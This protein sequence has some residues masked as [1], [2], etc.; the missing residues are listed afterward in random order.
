M[1]QKT[2]DRIAV[3][4]LG[5]VGLP[6]AVA[7]A[8]HF[9]V[10]GFDINPTRI[11]ELKEGFDRTG[12]I[13]SET[14]RST[15]LVSTT[16]PKD[17][18]GHTIYI[19]TV[20]TPVTTDNKPDLTPLQKASETVGNVIPRGA[21]VV[22]E[23]TVYPGVTEDFCGPIIEKCSGFQSGIDFFLGYSPE[24]INP[25][26]TVHTVDKITKVIAGQ[27]PEVVAKL[28][29]LYGNINNNN[30]FIAKNIKTAEA[31]KVIENTQ[32]DINIAFINDITMIV[33][34]LGGV[35]IYDV[36]AA[37]NTKWNF[38]PFQPG[39]VGGHCIGVD[40]YY[41]A[42][43]AEKLGH[44]SEIILAGR[45]TNENMA[46]F[47]ASTLSK[48]FSEPKKMLVLGLT[49]KEDIPDLRNTKVIELIRSLRKYGHQVDVHDPCALPEEAERFLGIQLQSQLQDLKEYDCVIGTVPHKGYR[50]FTGDTFQQL[51][52]PNGL[53]ADLK[54][55]WSTIE[56]P[57][58][59]GYW[60]L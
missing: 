44:Q 49:F 5:Y 19:I 37:A 35:S 12:E 24:R 41:L 20:P 6:L 56:L 42:E 7:L 45:R 8:K 47:V 4:G 54:N 27:T 46:D 50:A 22:F 43:C 18:Q 60:R 55:I 30:L 51:L 13:S 36:L 39:L 52:N 1:H 9:F 38:L 25:G 31:A 59:L 26:D 40:P 58:G 48:T 29:H 33:N 14:L 2:T 3:I 21:I 32:R 11:Q 17:L 34:K 57:K 28:A 53:V 23:S 16:H 15:R 10:T